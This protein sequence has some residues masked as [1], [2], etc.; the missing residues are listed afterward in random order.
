MGQPVG[1]VGQPIGWTE[2]LGGAHGAGPFARVDIWMD[3]AVSLKAVLF[4]SEQNHRI[5]NFKSSTF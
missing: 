2:T 4:G 3:G 5:L 1:L